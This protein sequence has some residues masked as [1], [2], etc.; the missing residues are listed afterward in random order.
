MVG[1]FIRK[2]HHICTFMLLSYTQTL[3]HNYYYYMNN[4]A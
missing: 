4:D 1:Y 2:F 3:Q